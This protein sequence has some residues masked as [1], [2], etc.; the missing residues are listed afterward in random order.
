MEKQTFRIE[1]FGC[2]V[3]RYD[4]QRLREMLESAGM[5]PAAEDETPDLWFINTCT[6]THVADRKARRIIRRR[7][8]E[9]PGARV[10][11]TGCYAD[12]RKDALKAIEHVD[13][14]YGRTEWEQ[15]IK[16]IVPEGFSPQDGG[17]V[18]FGV[19]NFRGRARAFLKIQDGCDSFCSYC[20]VP[21]TRGR[22]RSRSLRDTLEE[23][24]RMVGAGFR[25]LV[26]TGIHLGMYGGDLPGHSELADVVEALEGLDKGIRVRISSLEGPE[27]SDRLLAAMA[28]P[29]VCAHLHLPL[30]SGDV[31]VLAA[32]RRRYTP[33]AFR[34]VLDR[35][36]EA[37]DEPAISTDVM[38][39]FPGEDERAFRNTVEFCEN[40]GFSRLHVFCYSP[41]PGT[42]AYDMR[43]RID[44]AEANRRSEVLRALDA[45]MQADWARRFVGC[46][47]RVLYEK[48]ERDGWMYGYS[49][50]YIRVKAPANRS[51]VGRL[52]KTTLTQDSC[53]VPRI[54]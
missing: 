43:P 9:A 53:V 50:R 54:S 20:V 13:G 23:G 52:C 36:R 38:V 32:M 47:V 17:S 18:D 14:V 26:L 12:F 30:Q 49:D 45:R 48:V 2:K 22:P 1:T 11:V 28:L 27:V 29:G 3:N 24:K 16:D 10:F 35:V 44:P 37:L 6:V 40:A 5:Q 51:A 46:R 4:S 21:H 25:E 8:R 34:E 41:R 33:K 31:G 19:H 42:A 39:G 7:K 15:M